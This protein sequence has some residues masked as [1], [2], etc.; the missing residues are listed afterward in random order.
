[1]ML[2]LG[3]ALLAHRDGLSPAIRKRYIRLELV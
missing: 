1:M 3:M 2:S